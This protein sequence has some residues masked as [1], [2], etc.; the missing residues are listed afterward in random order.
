MLRASYHCIKGNGLHHSQVSECRAYLCTIQQQIPAAFY[1]STFLLSWNGLR[2]LGLGISKFA[3]EPCVK[4]KLYPIFLIEPLEQ[5]RPGH[6]RA[7]GLCRA[8]PAKSTGPSGLRPFQLYFFEDG[9]S[10]R[11][12]VKAYKIRLFTNNLV[13]NLAPMCPMNFA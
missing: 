10:W 5:I 8:G 3:N 12:I 1:R 2:L 6:H 9:L 11:C 7:F 4:N 13:A